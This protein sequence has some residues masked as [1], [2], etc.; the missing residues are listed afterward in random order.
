MAPAVGEAISSARLQLA[1]VRFLLHREHVEDGGDDGVLS[2]A[3][4]C[5][6]RRREWYSAQL[7]FRVWGIFRAGRKKR[8]T[9]FVQGF[10]RRLGACLV[11]VS[12]EE[13]T[14]ARGKDEHAIVLSSRHDGED[15]DDFVLFFFC[16]KGTWDG[17]GLC[18][19][20]DGGLLLGLSC[21]AAAVGKS[22]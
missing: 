11:T 18:W 3:R 9:R 1:P 19:P 6:N 10:I 4:G 20:G 13:R 7:G 17:V 8:A 5:S 15:E 2:W 14:P 22:R 21:W 12:D 16:R